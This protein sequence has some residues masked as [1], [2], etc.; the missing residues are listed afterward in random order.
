MIAVELLELYK[1]EISAVLGI[2]Q[3][4][5]PKYIR[6]ITISLLFSDLHCISFI[7][8]V[9]LVTALINSEGYKIN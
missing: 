1:N 9:E 3:V 7:G 2:G 4:L 5:P 6:G 8:I